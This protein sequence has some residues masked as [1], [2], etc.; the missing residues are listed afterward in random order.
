MQK[1]L[2]LEE[3]KSNPFVTCYQLEKSTENAKVAEICCDNYFESYFYYFCYFLQKLRN[4]FS[5]T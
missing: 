1:A 3:Y 5:F 4:L 2:V